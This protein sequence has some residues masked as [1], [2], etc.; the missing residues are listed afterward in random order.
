MAWVRK[1]TSCSASSETRRLGQAKRQSVLGDVD[2]GAVVLQ[3]ASG[4]LL[5]EIIARFVLVLVVVAAG[6]DVTNDWKP[7]GSSWIDHED[8]PHRQSMMAV[9]LHVSSSFH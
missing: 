3:V 9:A 2:E 7:W 5:D 1:A 4:F 6:I 8:S